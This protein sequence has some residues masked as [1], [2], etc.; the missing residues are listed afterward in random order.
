M[1]A[2]VAKMLLLLAIG[3]LSGVAACRHGKHA[4]TQMQAHGLLAARGAAAAAAAVYWPASV[5][6]RCKHSTA[7]LSRFACQLQA[8]LQ[9]LRAVAPATAAIAAD[10][11]REDTAAAR[12]A[13][14]EL[15][16]LML[17]CRRTPCC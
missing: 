4:S 5:Q 1:P 2:T 13:G 15:L 6:S 9:N 14:A 8:C 17:Q 11:Q 16:L 7:V 12:A 3:S 10:P